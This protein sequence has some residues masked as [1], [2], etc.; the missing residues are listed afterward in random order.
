MQ[1]SSI[2]LALLS[3]AA[4]TRAASPSHHHNAAAAPAPE[5]SSSIPPLASPRKSPIPILGSPAPAL[6]ATP[7]PVSPV[8]TSSPAAA[9]KP[10]SP[11]PA[12]EEE[13]LPPSP[14]LA[15]SSPPPSNATALDPDQLKA[16]RS[17]KVPIRDP[18]NI[19]AP[20]PDTPFQCDQGYPTRHLVSLALSYC[21]EES[22]LS[23]E[24][25]DALATTL[26]S[27]SFLHCPMPAIAFPAQ[28][29][30]SL[31]SLSIV[32]SLGR[33]TTSD[34]LTTTNSAITG[35]WLARF[36]RLSR[37]EVRD[38]VVNASGL[39]IILSNMT[40]LRELSI[41]NTT[42]GGHLV[43][44]WPAN[45][46]LLDLSNNR[47]QGGLPSL[48][49]QLLR[50]E[51]MDLGGNNISGHLPESLGHLRSVRKLVLSS[52]ALWGPIPKSFANL[53]SLAYL[54]MSGNKINGSIP[55]ALADLPS[56]RYV[57]L[58]NNDLDGMLPL[59][60]SS[61]QRMNSFRVA[62]N[63]S[64]CYNSSATSSKLVLG[65]AKCDEDGNPIVPSS[66]PSSSSGSSSSTSP[67]GDSSS[68]EHHSSS[69]SVHK[70]SGVKKTVWAIA[71]A[72]GAIFLF[73]VIVVALSR[74]CK[75]KG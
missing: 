50:L 59:N 31:E 45:L 70:S 73:I 37:L 38:I 39:A 49:G 28:M 44:S 65:L 33:E 16:L 9:R 71:T 51:T 27:L 56:I 74:W 24:A 57:D 40:G 55:E 35:V 5:V 68:G 19:C 34:D 62:G 11:S 69:S 43:R 10:T 18:D 13:P 36:H 4:S 53:T 14:L 6:P 41:S 75:N 17:L 26:K 46:T 72:L 66:S 15:P 30:S 64:L 23:K 32:S 7:S 61:I 20:Y 58:R 21:P 47:I 63:P 29:T 60:S 42:L 3:I 52:N 67:W 25:L 54:D 48:F 12:P 8:P 1:V 22:V 2:L